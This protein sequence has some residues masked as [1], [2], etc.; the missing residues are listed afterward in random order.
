MSLED[1]LKQLANPTIATALNFGN[2]RDKI[3]INVPG[4]PKSIQAIAATTINSTEVVVVFD[5]N[6]Q[7]WVRSASAPQLISEQTEFFFKSRPREP[8]IEENLGGLLVTASNYYRGQE[9]LKVIPAL[10]KRLAGGKAKKVACHIGPTYTPLVEFQD[11]LKQLG[12]KVSNVKVLEQDVLSSYDILIMRVVDAYENDYLG[13]ATSELIGNFIKKGNLVVAGGCGCRYGSTSMNYFLE[14]LQLPW[15]IKETRSLGWDDPNF[16]VT[17]PFIIQG[18]I[19]FNP[20]LTD[21]TYLVGVE[22]KNAIIRSANNLVVAAFT[23]T[24]AI[25]QTGTTL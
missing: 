1:Y 17:Y 13:K 5:S 24:L 20:V 14:W 11:A 23:S 9:E 4:F 12:F 25:L 10:I 7:A 2:E 3:W 6:G 22:D 19:T 18:K 16:F 21:R 8:I 15:R